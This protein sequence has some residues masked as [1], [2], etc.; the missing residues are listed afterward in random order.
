M[1]PTDLAR[2]WLT[3][4]VCLAVPP[5]AGAKAGGKLTFD[6]EEHL[7]AAALAD[8]V[9][10]LAG[11]AARPRPADVLKYEAPV[12]LDHARRGVVAEGPI[13]KND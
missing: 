7:L 6:V 12:C 8:V 11:V 10:R 4:R 2:L 13:L 3:H 1:R 5:A 9:D